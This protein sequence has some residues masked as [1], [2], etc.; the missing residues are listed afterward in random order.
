MMD[1]FVNVE[2]KYLSLLLLN[3]PEESEIDQSSAID[4][5]EHFHFIVDS[6]L[7]YA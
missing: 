3:N 2:K 1:G 6:W 7:L 5:H 4:E